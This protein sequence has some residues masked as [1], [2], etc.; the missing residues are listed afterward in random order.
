MKSIKQNRDRKREKDKNNLKSSAHTG[1]DES[2]VV[3]FWLLKA[4]FK[5]VLPTHPSIHATF[6]E[7][8]F[9]GMISYPKFFCRMIFK[10]NLIIIIDFYTNVQLFPPSLINFI[11]RCQKNYSIYIQMF[12][13]QAF[14]SSV[15]FNLNFL[16][17]WP[18]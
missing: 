5:R 18:P 15:C 8:V 6:Q 10:W 16:F 2:V 11:I 13:F 17:E 7:H 4:I 14:Y 9:W 12:N 1:I 3:S